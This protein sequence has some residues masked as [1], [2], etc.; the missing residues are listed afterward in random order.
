MR[1]SKKRFTKSRKTLI[2]LSVFTIFEK[3]GSAFLKN[4]FF[5]LSRLRPVSSWV[6]C[7]ASRLL[8]NPIWLLENTNQS[9]ARV[10][11]ARD[12]LPERVC[13]REPARASLTRESPTRAS[14]AKEDL[15]R[16]SPARAS[17]ARASPARASPARASPPGGA[18]LYVGNEFRLQEFLP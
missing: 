11:P 8:E 1:F 15:A 6:M 3:V 16:A 12:S 10:S 7:L 2:F 4:L 14:P 17:L 5:I 13:Q 9:L 18:S